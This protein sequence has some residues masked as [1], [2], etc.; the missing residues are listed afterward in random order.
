MKLVFEKKI[1]NGKYCVVIKIT[2]FS[3]DEIER[4]K[5]YGAPIVS[6][7]PQSRM[8]RIRGFVS[9]ISL[10][11]LNYDYWF[12]NKEK[13]QLFESNMTERIK[14]AIK[15]LKSYN[16]DFTEEKEISL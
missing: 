11:D 6:I 16:D 14:E 7:A 13:A 10:P 9:E 15:K 1:E 5:K 8:N 3:V 4:M 12:E 2:E